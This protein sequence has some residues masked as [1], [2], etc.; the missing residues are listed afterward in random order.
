[1]T[2]Q[3]NS[4]A[5]RWG[6]GGEASVLKE[7][8][9][10]LRKRVKDLERHLTLIRMSPGQRSLASTGARAVGDPAASSAAAAPA[11]AAATTTAPAVAAQVEPGG[12]AAVAAVT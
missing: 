4:V 9:T 8:V 12:G 5:T 2:E 10:E 11:P 1:M 7:E 3:L 6:S